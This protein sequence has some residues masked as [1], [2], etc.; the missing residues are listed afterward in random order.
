MIQKVSKIDDSL[1][2]LEK[3]IT[4]NGNYILFDKISLSESHIYY[5]FKIFFA[6]TS[7]G[8]SENYSEYSNLINKLLNQKQNHLFEIEN[9]KSLKKDEMMLINEINIKVSNYW[10]IKDE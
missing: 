7:F 3:P 2:I 10:S 4:S 6:R 5:H 9:F 8:T 1:I